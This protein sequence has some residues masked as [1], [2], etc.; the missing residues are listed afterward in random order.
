MPTPAQY[1]KPEVGSQAATVPSITAY[2]ATGTRQLR[3]IGF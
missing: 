2:A 3:C 1:P